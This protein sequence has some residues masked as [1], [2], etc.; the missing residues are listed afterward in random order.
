MGRKGLSEEV[1]F[2]QDPEWSF[3]PQGLLE[4]HS[5]SEI[6]VHWPQEG[7]V[8]G[9]EGWIAGDRDGLGRGPGVEARRL[10]ITCRA[11]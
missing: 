8:G 1:K 3:H 11:S 7:T 6:E 10:C 4:E 2:E 9:A 5:G